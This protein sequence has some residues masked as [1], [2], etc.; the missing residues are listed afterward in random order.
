MVIVVCRTRNEERN[1]ERFCTEYAKIVDKILI[2]DGGSEDNTIEIA[3]SMP[4]TIVESYGERVHKKGVWRNPHGLHINH[5][6]RRAREEGADWILFDD[7]DSVPNASM[8]KTILDV[9]K[10][11]DIQIIK[12]VRLYLYKDEGHFEK[13]SGAGFGVWGWRRDTNVSASEDD[14]WVHHMDYDRDVKAIEIPKPNCLLHF[15]CPDEEEITRKHEFYKLAKSESTAHPTA[16]GGTV[17]PLPEWAV[18]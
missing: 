17:V 2:S 9:F 6:I 12:M 10:M 18:I 4:K 3:D 13:M 15:F 16:F 11:P 1:I 14:P 8:K 5:M 7:C